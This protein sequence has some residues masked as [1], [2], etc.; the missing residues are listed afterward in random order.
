MNKREAR[1]QFD[2]ATVDHGW[3]GFSAGGKCVTLRGVKNDTG[4][5]D[6]YL[7]LVEDEKKDMGWIVGIDHDLYCRIR[8]A[9]ADIA[10]ENTP[11]GFGVGSSDVNCY[12]DEVCFN[13]FG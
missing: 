13:L 2:E 4:I 12:L 5:P 11:E 6:K 7:V 1:S 3:P 10:V 9:A 8:R